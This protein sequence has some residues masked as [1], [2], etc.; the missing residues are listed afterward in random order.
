MLGSLTLGRVRDVEVKLHPTFGLVVLWAL[1]S[2]GADLPGLAA[3]GAALFGLLLVCLV[4]ACVLLHELGHSFMAMH[5]GHRV[6][7]VTLSV[8]G[9][10]A[11]IEYFPTRPASEMM[12]ALAGPA[13]NLAILVALLPPLLLYGVLSGFDA[14][15]DYLAALAAFDVSAGGLLL[16]LFY[17]NA[18]IAIF[19]LLPAFPMDGGRILRAALSLLV[20]REAGT[21]T[22]VLVGQALAVAFAV[23]SLVWLGNV[24]A[25][26]IAVFVVVMAQAEGRAVRLEGAMRRLRVGQFALWD[27]G[28]IAPGRR[29]T[30]ALRGGPRDVAVTDGGRVVGMLWRHELLHE[31]RGGGHHLTVGDVM[32]PDVVTAGVDESVYDVQQRMNRLNRWAIP[33]VEDGLYRGLFTADRF[34]H[35]YHQIAPFPA[36]AR[37][38]ADLVDVLR[39]AVRSWTK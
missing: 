13:V 21:R 9:G 11:R 12:I 3:A 19:N 28:G 37:R 1:Y 2:Y 33:V 23:A 22:A 29:L 25:V 14:P 4:F 18:L 10:V 24:V 30:D 20:G 27:M 16:G 15:G 39:Q 17:A 26:L 34:V 35:V 38:L 8:I 32:D 36:A 7:D 5:Y 31:L 6:R